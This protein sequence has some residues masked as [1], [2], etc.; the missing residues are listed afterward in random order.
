MDKI[1]IAKL[2]SVIISISGMV[3][4][5]GWFLDIELLKSILPVWVTM[6]FLTAL[7]FFL[8][9]LLLY[10]VIRQ[11]EQKTDISHLIITITTLIILLVM[12]TFLLSS[13]FNTSTGI[14]D[15]FVKEPEGAIKTV[16]PGR[17]SIGT[18][19]NFLLVA[20]IGILTLF[21]IKKLDIKRYFIGLI[22]VVTGSIAI[23]GHILSKPILYYSF[24]G[25]STAMAIHTAILFV[26]LG[27]GFFIIGKNKR[28]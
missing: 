25:Y 3:V 5:A 10:S 26:L 16:N 24:E 4:M 14:E 28:K 13:L 22:I 9:G 27:V 23:L 15:L 1:K 20:L 7:S 8:S 19:L 18:M 6:K 11:M 12:I 21:E 2:V 17:P